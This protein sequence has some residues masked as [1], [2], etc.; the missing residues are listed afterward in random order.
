MKTLSRRPIFDVYCSLHLTIDASVLRFFA[1][2]VDALGAGGVVA[3][4][5]FLPCVI[6]VRY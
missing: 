6:E 2:A 1:L 3:F 4:G 5:T